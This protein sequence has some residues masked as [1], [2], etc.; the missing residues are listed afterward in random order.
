MLNTN[1][2]APAL[3][4]DNDADAKPILPINFVDLKA[5][6]ALIRDR[7][8][9]GIAAVLDHGK[10]IT[11]PEH[12][13][14]EKA[15]AEWTGAADVVL[16][17]NG[18]EALEIAMMGEGVG[19][20]DAVFIPGFTYNATASA[21]L[22]VGATPVFVDVDEATRNIDP[23]D[24]VRRI[25]AVKAQGALTPKMVIPVDLFGL[26][27]DY[28]ALEKVCATYGL[29][30]LSD[31]AQAFGGQQNDRWV[32]NISP[33]TT[34]SFF[35][36][37]SLGCYGDGGAI[38][39]RD[40][41]KADIWRSI[42]WHGTDAAKRESVRIGTNGRFDT[43]QAAVLLCKLSLFDSELKRRREIAEIYL[44][45]LK[46]KVELPMEPENTLSG[47][48]YFSITL[49]DRDTVQ[50]RLGEHEVPSAIYYKIPLHQMTAFEAFAPEGGLPVCERLANRILHLPIDP[51]LSDAQVHYVCEKLIEVL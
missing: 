47:W 13:E 18:T 6:Q 12:D 38:F 40:Q 11:G 26:P 22:M 32:G 48:G 45:R 15:L 34:T 49:D 1:S 10:Y 25:E 21:V 39:A 7:I 3:A 37:K 44:D 24:L 46:G 2:D 8:D 51:Y 9:A 42:R 50:K 43:I 28:P 36:A 19:Q 33:M 31:G 27:A 4:N 5:Q 29:A 14:L 16:C 23:E 30:M 20:G 41:D 17:G 35:P